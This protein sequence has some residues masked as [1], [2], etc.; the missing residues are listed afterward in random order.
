MLY[1]ECEHLTKEEQDIRH[2]LIYL[3]NPC[4][5]HLF[6][7]RSEFK[8]FAYNSC[9]QTAIFG[10]VFLLQQL[11]G[12]KVS[13]FE[14]NFTDVIYNKP[15][16]Y[17]HAFTVIEKAGKKILVDISRTQRQ[18]LFHMI[19]D[20][21]Y[22][23]LKGYEDCKLIEYEELDFCSLLLNQEEEFLTKMLP[24]EVMIKAWDKY[25]ALKKKPKS[26]QLNFACNIYNETTG[27]GDE[28]LS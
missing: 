17:K 9:R 20:L 15:V 12:Y 10:S 19:Q 2:E 13:A 11:P 25:K 22:P 4:L 23:R 28:F 18:L 14:G 3:F 24:S 21:V 5:K 1:I 27:I 7:Q 16:D 6:N 8:E 26:E